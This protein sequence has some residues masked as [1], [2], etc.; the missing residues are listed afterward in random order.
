MKKINQNRFY[1]L[2]FAIVLI[3]TSCVEKNILRICCDDTLLVSIYKTKGDYFN[4]L[5]A[6]DETLPLNQIDLHDFPL[7]V[8]GTDSVYYGRY[9][10]N[11]GYAGGFMISKDDYFTDLTFTEIATF[12]ESHPDVFYYPKDSIKKHIIDK[13]P[14]V[15]F[16]IDEDTLFRSLKDNR[17]ELNRIIENCE[18]DKYLKRLK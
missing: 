14:F 8:I 15:E 4:N 16:Y 10:L 3:I 17:E 5:N 6:N 1:L 18:L 13:D 2:V 7:R 9:R 12:L 11:N